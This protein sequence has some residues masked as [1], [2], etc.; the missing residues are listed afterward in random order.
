MTKQLILGAS[1]LI[2]AGVSVPLTLSTPHSIPAAA[3][4]LSTPES[5]IRV[6]EN[7]R[8]DERPSE[9][10]FLGVVV[11]LQ[12]IDLAATFAGTLERLDVRVGDQV[13]GGTTIARLDGRSITSDLEMAEAALRVAEAEHQ[14]SVIELR[15]ASDHM[16][17]LHTIRDLFSREQLAHAESQK[18]LAAARLRA[19]L[20]ELAGRQARSVQLKQL[21]EDAQIVAP[22]DGTIAA[23]YADAGATVSRGTPLVRVIGLR[24]FV[25]RFAVPEEQALGIT[26]GRKVC[27][28]IASAEITADGVI[29]SIAPEID[30]ALR[31]LI[32][33]ARLATEDGSPRTPPF[34]AVARVLL[35]ADP[36]HQGDNEPFVDARLAT[37]E[38][39]VGHDQ[40][41][42]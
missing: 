6:A 35:A 11:A 13:K 21:L 27:V 3:S 1:F 18:D 23:R 9:A 25:I 30:A 39:R 7:I 8:R 22:F 5:G 15:D 14:R 4:S 19:S 36:H 31:M 41:V 29:D 17:R 10:G 34:G 40:P 42:D 32:V 2:A 37:C 33:E 16:A 12:S 38:R 26:L 20:A 24:S 28:H